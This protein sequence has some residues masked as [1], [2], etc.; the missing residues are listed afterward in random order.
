MIKP[1]LMVKCRILAPKS[2][3][4]EVIDALYDLGLYHL[5][6]HLKGDYELDIGEPLAKA[7]ELS[8]LLVKIRHLL[9]QFPP[10]EI[11]KALPLNKKTFRSARKKVNQ[12]SSCFIKVEEELK[13]GREKRQKLQ[14]N[15]I[16]LE[17]LKKVDVNI[18]DLVK[19]KKLTYFFG[20][21]TKSEGL[22]STV[23]KVSDDCSLAKN[24]KYVFLVGR[25]EQE[26][27]L[28]AA[29]NEFGY[30]PFHLDLSFSD[31][32]KEI[33]TQKEQFK[34]LTLKQKQLERKLSEIK[35]QLPEL[36]RLGLQLSEEV[37]KQ[38]LPLSFA[39]TKSSFL[40]EGW[41]P[42]EKK[43][44][45]QK[46]LEKATR[47]KIEIKFTEPGKKDS[48]PVKLHN[49]K[50]VSPFE[51][52]LKL[53]GLP[54]YQEID[55]TS[56]LFLTFPLFFGFMLGDV[57]YGL[58]LFLVFYF[59]RKK[60]TSP[61][62]RQLL[63]VMIF[64]ALVSMIFGLVFGEV[65]GFEYVGAETG[66]QLCERYGICLQKVVHESHDHQEVV[67]YFPHLLSRA[68]SHTKIFG[69]EILTVLVVGAIIGFIHLNLGFLF[70]FVN[71]LGSHGF[72]HAFTAKISWMILEVGLIL[73][74]MSVLGIL[75][76]LMT[77]VGAIIAVLGVVLLGKG[78]G[79]QGIVELPSLF[80]NI[81]SYMRLGAVGLAS[82]GLAVVVNEKLAQPFLE[83]GGI[84]ILIA[85]LIMILGHAINLLLG[86]IGPF[87]HG[88]RLHYV[89]CFSKFFQGGGEEYAPFARNEKIEKALKT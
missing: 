63:E 13:S 81:L 52:L 51:F 89:E 33:K 64:A 67:W 25:K 32:K 45:I 3:C 65:F 42:K 37:K 61:S 16:P 4:S 39:V 8:G 50:L 83:R 60:V 88:V 28:R 35:N 40:A 66:S 74:V 10:M 5:T 29:L 71:E 73:A 30:S 9:S 58:V 70:G 46:T 17:I 54:R 87:L 78:E 7:E 22:E 21:I 68:S 79:V 31:F 36:A 72:W 82:V 38:E 11:K 48:P 12:L 85:L 69:Y 27:E 76:P 20:S 43:D 41:V 59:I 44:L 47:G 23:Q 49:K 55:P 19:S 80:S 53:Y 2:Y 62:F 14:S 18:L 86:I 57:G 56:L 34:K 24:S 75:I 1:E 6:P 15:L 26:P 84:F 77:W